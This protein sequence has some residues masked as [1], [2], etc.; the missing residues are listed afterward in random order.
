MVPPPALTSLMSMTGM[1]SGWPSAWYSS[2]VWTIP[3][4]TM[5]HFAVVPPMS[6]EISRPAPR[7]RARLAQPVAPAAG[8][9]S[10]V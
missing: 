8:P 1:R 9:D 5:A 2:V 3:P 6:K 10:M 4:S 7:M